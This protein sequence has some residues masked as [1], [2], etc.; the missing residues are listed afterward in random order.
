MEISSLVKPCKYLAVIPAR[1]GSKGVP[2]KNLR[3]LNGKALIGW[4]IEQALEVLPRTNIILSTDSQEIADVAKQHGLDI[5]FL[6][7]TK[8][9][10]DTTPTEPVLIHALDWYT[11]NH[12]E[13]DAVILLQPTSPFRKKLSLS[14]AIEQYEKNGADSLVSVTENHHFFW[15]HVENPEALYDYKNRPRRQ[16]I[17]ANQRWYREN[18]SIYITS[19]DILRKNANRI[20]GKISIFVMSEEESWEI[21]SLNDF[22]IVSSLMAGGVT[23]DC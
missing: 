4:T 1:G 15:R 22:E 12:G 7:P 14:K 17:S 10:Q 11:E 20:G 19:T 5:P 9:A 6:R 23:H 18:G 8:L 21:D 3:N 2:N 13:I 16:D